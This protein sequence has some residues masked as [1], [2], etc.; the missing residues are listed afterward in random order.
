MPNY[1]KG[2]GPNSAKLMVVGEAPGAEEERQGRNFV[3]ATGKIV[4]ESLRSTGID[5]ESVYY[6]NVVKIRPPSNSI[7]RLK[8]YGQ[9]IKDFIPQLWEEIDSLQPN[10]ILAFGNT[11]LTALTGLEGIES[12]RGSIL[13]S[14]Y[15]SRK[16]VPTIHPA[17]LMHGE[18]DGKLRSW[19]DLT[20]IKW[21]IA[22]AVKQSAFPDIHTPKRNLIACK[23]NLELYRFLNKNADKKLVATDIETFKTIPVCI[24]FAFS[25]NEAISVPLF[26]NLANNE[27]FPLTRSDVVQN[28]K[29]IAEFLG[30]NHVQKIGQNFKFDE[31]LLALSLNDTLPIGLVTRG[32]YFDNL[33]AFRTLY[34]ELPGS[35]AFQTSVLT[36]EPY[37]KEEG[38]GYNP[39]KD[40]IERLLLYNAKDSA[41]SYECYERE[42]EELRARNLES[43]FFERVMPLHPFYSRMERRGIKRDAFAKAF[44]DEK[45][46][47]LQQERQIELN[48]LCEP[49]GVTNLNVNSNGMNNQVGKLLFVQMQL[50]IRK[51][52]D[53]KTIDA[54]RRNVLKGTST[55]T[56]AKRRILELIL[57]I[58]KIRKTRGTYIDAKPHSDGKLRTSVRIMLESGRTATG[59][60]QPPVTTEKM[61]IAF[62][63]ITKH[64][65]FGSDLRSMFVPDSGYV[66]IEPDLSQ[67]EARVVAVLARDEK[68]VKMFEYQVDIH[69]VTS[70][71]V[72]GLRV[73]F[74][75]EFFTEQNP[76][77]CQSLA[78]KINKT[79]KETTTDD[80]RQT[81]K[82][83]RHAGHYDMGKHEASEQIGIPEFVAGQILQKF[84]A[85]N[86][87]IKGVFHAE[88]KDFLN[89]NNRMLTNPFGRTRQFL[90]KWGEDL[91]K[92]AYAQIP[93]STVSDQ[94]KFAMIRIE[95]RAPWLEILQESHDSFLAQCPLLIGS[96]SPFALV[97]RTYP[98]IKEELEMPINFTNCSLGTGNLV[99]PSEIKM[100]SKSWLEMERVM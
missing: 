25:A 65:E 83:F 61:G 50:P 34:P 73:C 19:A 48:G 15:G 3:G 57:Q 6:T 95:K 18:G 89:K 68:L 99:I 7:K 32:F 63:T 22:R 33:L 86:P 91:W 21:D 60:L 52:T 11:A 79:L 14:C 62:Q 46:K 85:T 51:G 31:F 45:Y 39:K 75:D 13:P 27:D 100:G 8:E 16:V 78:K 40:K 80:E 41:I 44:L 42:L 72:K 87:N 71:W 24:S 54:I 17:S 53:E 43:F 9:E 36:E 35:L 88:I 76:H 69:R 66:F 1:V 67:A 96:L 10:C 30:D 23:S 82:K 77:E 92:E 55:E 64:G 94:V 20:F 70:S 98:I 81:G 49:Y 5:P 97:D 29:D 26:S 38:K 28:W 93:Q 37:Y 58:R 4:R 59:I 12:Y 84:H 56:S 74:L 90:N 2:H 47:D